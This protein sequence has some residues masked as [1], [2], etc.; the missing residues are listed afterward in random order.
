[1]TTTIKDTT[2]VLT[3]PEPKEFVLQGLLAKLI[4]TEQF[5]QNRLVHL[6]RMPGPMQL[7]GESLRLSKELHSI[8]N[9]ITFLKR[10]CLLAYDMLTEQEQWVLVELWKRTSTAG[11][12]RYADRITSL[13]KQRV[14][15]EI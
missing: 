4:D 15:K 7:E 6:S 14:C 10:W 1:M 12:D 5:F 2:F 3:A 13:V 8:D 9:S 11:M